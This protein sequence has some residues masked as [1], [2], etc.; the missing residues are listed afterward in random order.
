[1]A[2]ATIGEMNG[3][4]AMVLK[5]SL[6][7]FPIFVSFGTGWATWATREIMSTSY[8][9]FTSEDAKSLEVKMHSE[10]D[11]LSN[12]IHGMPPDEWRIRVMNLEEDGK[13]SI[14][15]NSKILVEL[16]H[17]KEELD[18]LRRVP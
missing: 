12:R 13:E 7:I 14:R 16:D 3:R 4:W 15:Q 10:I 5:M 17:I 9:M 8:T 1:M 6:I 11:E 18:R 2:K